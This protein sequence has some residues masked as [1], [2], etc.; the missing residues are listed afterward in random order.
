MTSRKRYLAV[1]VIAFALLVLPAVAQDTS[2]EDRD[3]ELAK[4]KQMADEL[5][6]KVAEVVGLE[7]GD[8]VTIKVTTRAEVRDFLLK[9]L[10]EEYPGDELER[11]GRCLA[12]LG[13][14]PP[15]Y[16]L[17]TGLIDILHEQAGAF[18]DP[19]T[20]AFYSIVDLPQELKVPL[21]ER[22]I[23][24]H[25]LTHA[26]QDREVD[27]LKL[28]KNDRDNSDLNYAHTS[29]MEGMASVAMFVA[30]QG[31]PA[32][33]LPDLGAIMRMSMGA[34]ANNPMMK[35]FTS[36]P[37]YLQESL[38]SPYAEGASFVQA[39][40]KANPETKPSRLLS[41]LPVS[42]EQILNFEKFVSADLPT[43][44]DITEAC[45]LLPP[46]WSPFYGDYLGEFDIKVLCELHEPTREEAREI[47]EGWDGIRYN[48][49]VN[50]DD[51]LLVGASVWD[52]EKDA[53]E[54]ASGF[55]QALS[56]VH[57]QED[58]VVERCGVRVNFVVGK[59]GSD[60][61]GR[62]MQA[63]AASPTRE[64]ATDSSDSY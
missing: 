25:E 56:E 8:P 41:E 35:I 59:L 10:E 50:G 15:D 7:M 60:L 44:I 40:L 48:S 31:M 17:R 37:K 54:F 19:R 6:P 46:E 3:A 64:M 38:V 30:A 43:I 33:R 58:I 22:L 39:Y 61:K 18:Y 12:T 29:V 21:V 62:V 45:A 24:A 36:S 49:F 1:A 23:V 32:D 47:A 13:L 55:K 51:L 4:T 52:S 57:K 16:D 20:K 2:Q 42:S 63:L 11:Q 5:L 9:L 14:L 53:E 27:L 28:Q 34:A 26:L